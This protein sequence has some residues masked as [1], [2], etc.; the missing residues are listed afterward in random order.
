MPTFRDAHILKTIA[1]D[2]L[3][4]EISGA[5]LFGR[6]LGYQETCLVEVGYLPLKAARIFKT[7]YEVDGY[8]LLPQEVHDHLLRMANDIRD[9][10]NGGG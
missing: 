9:R 7:A 1:R 6:L 4:A 8:N 10:L 2:V 5:D 3:E